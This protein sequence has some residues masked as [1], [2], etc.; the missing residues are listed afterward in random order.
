[1]YVKLLRSARPLD[2]VVAAGVGVTADAERAK[3][4]YRRAADQGH[5]R[6]MHNLGVL[7][8]GR[9]QEQGDYAG[10]SHWFKEAAKRGYVDS[11]FNLATLYAHGR[12]VPKDLVES[13]MWF[14]LAA[15]SGDAGSL[16]RLEEIKAQLDSSEREAGEQKLAAWR[17]KAAEPAT[18][19]R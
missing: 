15:R 9:G 19:G 16:R 13:Y 12:G 1:M 8:A 5:V 14:A 3:V 4:W 2:K 17:P 10:A 11:Q 6:A 7:V 18:A